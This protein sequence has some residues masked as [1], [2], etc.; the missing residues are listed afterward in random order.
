MAIKRI[1]IITSGGD[2]GGLNAVIKGAGLMGLSLGIEMVIIPNGYAGL[3]NLSEMQELTVLTPERLRLIKPSLAGSEA[4]HSRVKIKK[5]S[6][7]EKYE[8]IKNGLKKFAIDALVISGGDDTGSVIVDLT[9]QGI[10]C[11]HVPKTMDL[12]LQTY[13][14]GG[15]SAVNRIAGFVQDL[16][17]TGL[18]HNRVIVM[19]VFGRYAGHTALRGGIA[20][21]A[22]CILIP[23]IS[24]DFD[25]VYRH[26]KKNFTERVLAS[27]VKAGTYSIVVAEGI[28]DAKGEVITDKAAGIDAFGHAKLAGAGKYVRKQ[29]EERMK[30]DPEI[31]E[32][33]Q[34][35]YMWTPG[36]Y[37]LPEIREVT[38]G[39]LVRSGKS[40]AYD[41]N[42]GLR[43]GAAA[44]LL[45]KDGIAGVTL[46]DVNDKKIEYIPTEDAIKQRKVDLDEL[47]LYESLGLC[48]G[49][50]PEPF[51]PTPVKRGLP[52][53][54]FF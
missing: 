18:S 21:E 26:M 53:S 44:V 31:K 38:P 34:K 23:E 3:Y 25:V 51:V 37:E 30:N 12:D 40:S 17:T 29:M 19:E 13:S 47:S 35:A 7:P 42:F 46:V 4:G 43:T 45:L 41:V 36:V 39:H 14:V 54:R 1:G 9:A 20:G 22:D 6:D 50:E 11:I 8:R 28:T 16:Q 49:R 27:D 24:V 2:C 33:M 10:S 48:F 52:V 5:I 32:F 15:D